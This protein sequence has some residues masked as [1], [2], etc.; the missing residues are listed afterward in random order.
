M[1]ITRASQKA[2]FDNV[3]DQRR[4]QPKMLR[5]GLYA[6]VS[7]NDQQ[8]LPMQNRALRKGLES[9]CATVDALEGGPQTVQ[10][11]PISSEELKRIADS[12]DE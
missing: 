8:T 12:L 3:F 4:R 6:R 10:I 7:T 11:S 1:P 9:R 2:N 5:A